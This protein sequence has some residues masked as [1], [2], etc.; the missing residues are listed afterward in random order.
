MTNKEKL[1]ELIDT[2]ENGIITTNRATMEGIYRG[3]FSDLIKDGF[4]SRYGRGLYIKNDTWEDDFYLLQ[5]RYTK[6]IYSNE[7]ALYLH[8]YCDKTPAKYTMSFPKGYNASSLK[9]ENVI[10]RRAIPKIYSLGI[11]EINSPSGNPIRVYDLERTLCDI[12]RGKKTDIQIINSAMKQY[13]LNRKKNL[14]KLIQYADVLHV[15]EKI[16]QYLEILL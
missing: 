6:G 3:A 10:T 16:L 15:K 4:L 2:S 11:I 14:H 5:Q 1:K 9:N 7:T 12:L 8:G 13:V